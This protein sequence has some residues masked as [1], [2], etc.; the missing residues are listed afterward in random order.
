MDGEVDICGSEDDT[1]KINT[2]PA[3][4]ARG[5][6]LSGKTVPAEK[7]CMIAKTSMA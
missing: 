1:D 2:A 7:D 4:S 3:K 6:S 5:E